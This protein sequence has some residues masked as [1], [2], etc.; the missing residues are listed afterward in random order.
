MV[1]RALKPG[2]RGWQARV[3]RGELM[4]SKRPESLASHAKPRAPPSS[5]QEK[6]MRSG[7]LQYFGLF[8][9]VKPPELLNS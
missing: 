6:K 1:N 2:V 5:S 9:T 4:D 3:R 7:R 8:L